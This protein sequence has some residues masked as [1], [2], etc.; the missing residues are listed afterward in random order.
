MLRVEIQSTEP[1]ADLFC[2]GRIVLGVEAE[3]LRCMVSSRPEPQLVLHMAS[4]SAIDAAGLGLLVELHHWAQKRNVSLTIA[5][6]SSRV[7]KLLAMTNLDRVLPVRN[8]GVLQIAER[9][10]EEWRTMTA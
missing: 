9:S 10:S 1:I 4:V 5:D 2:S 8:S 6:P 7:E 3:T